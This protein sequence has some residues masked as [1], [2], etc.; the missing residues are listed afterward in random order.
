[1]GPTGGRGGTSSAP[2]GRAGHV[3]TSLNPAVP[4]PLSREAV[5]NLVMVG[6]FDHLGRPR[7]RI[8]WDVR[9]VYE[10]AG[11]ERLVEPTA[12]ELP[13]PE[14]TELEGTAAAYQPT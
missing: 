13:L 9:D 11:Q 12:E 5:E 2:D 8:L 4:A 6:A 1:M 14:M 3:G 7:R 10:S